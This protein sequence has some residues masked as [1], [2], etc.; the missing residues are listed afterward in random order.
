[1]ASCFQQGPRRV[2]PWAIFLSVLL[3]GA[4]GWAFWSLPASH[5]RPDVRVVQLDTR[6]EG[7]AEL[8]VTL[9]EPS[10][11]PLPV[12][13]TV[14]A[15]KPEPAP[16]GFSVSD[17]HSTKTNSGSEEQDD[18]HPEQTNPGTGTTGPAAVKGA[19]GSGHD[20]SG[21]AG[22]SFFQIS[23]QAK[24]VIYVIDRSAS[25]GLNGSF[26]LAKQ[27]LIA[28]LERLPAETQFQVIAYNRTAE[29][30]RIDGRSDLV[31]ATGEHKKRVAELLGDLY[32]EGG[33]SHLPALMRAISLKPEVIFFLTD[34]DDLRPEQLRAVAMSNRERS[35]IHAVE[36]GGR[37]RQDNLLRKLAEENHG[38]Y[39]SVGRPD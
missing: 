6:A 32:A 16:L 39:R 3:H 12:K 34:A 14:E 20:G 7:S 29:P 8:S 10:P 23:T 28:S 1:M 37:R 17:D 31:L 5:L 33:T 2:W 15:T 22:T 24:S 13:P 38:V 26:D 4:L 25:M 30:L 11:K 18:H 27:E 19:V 35:V 36:L 21:E 9:V